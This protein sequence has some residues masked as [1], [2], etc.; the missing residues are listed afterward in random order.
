MG[1]SLSPA[2]STPSNNV[3]ALAGTAALNSARLDGLTRSNRDMTRTDAPSA[4]P[5]TA[6]AAPPKPAGP[7]P[8]P[9]IAGLSATQ[10][11]NAW[12]IVQ[13][14]HKM[15][16]S[17]RGQQIAIATAMQESNLF[18]LK[19]AVDH[20]S[21]GLFQQ[22]PSSGWGSKKQLVNPTYAAHAFYAVLVKHKNT[23]GTLWLAAQTVQRSAFPH[24]YQK[25]ATAAAKVVKE[26]DKRF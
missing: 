12:A 16:V 26:L 19:K 20:D 21:L 4:A 24:A 8:L 1:V 7:P 5:A 14:G 10:V 25:H 13:E 9:K 6:P 2:S 22:R 23:W 11:K 18:N 15:G 3:P 17:S